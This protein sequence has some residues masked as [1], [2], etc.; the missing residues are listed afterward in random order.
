MPTQHPQGSGSQ[1]SGH[2]SYPAN[3]VPSGSQGQPFRG[4]PG[5]QDGEHG[6]ATPLDKLAA[7]MSEEDLHAVI[8]QLTKD[9]KELSKFFFVCCNSSAGAV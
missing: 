3:I 4:H 9:Q 2:Q 5:Q 8:H 7:D 1:S 6:R